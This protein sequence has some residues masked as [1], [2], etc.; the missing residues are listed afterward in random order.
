MTYQASNISYQPHWLRKIDEIAITDWLTS[1]PTRAIRFLGL[2]LIHFFPPTLKR[3]QRVLKRFFPFWYSL[4][5][6]GSAKWF[7]LSHEG[8]S[9]LVW[10]LYSCKN[11]ILILIFR[12]SC[13]RILFFTKST[14][15]IPLEI[16]CLF[17]KKKKSAPA[18]F[19]GVAYNCCLN[20]IEETFLFAKREKYQLL[21]NFE[22]DYMI[23]CRHPHFFSALL[24]TVMPGLFSFP[25]FFLVIC[26]P[27]LTILTDERDET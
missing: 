9:N 18:W 25:F 5:E 3:V 17:F 10:R 16:I 21:R 4:K 22:V 15:I 13:E 1:Y 2:H 24:T 14:L 20:M 6:L 8:D 19:N 26:L 11:L 12:C 27:V 23:T 7:C